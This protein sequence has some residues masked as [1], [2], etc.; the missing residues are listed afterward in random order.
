MNTLIGYA[1]ASMGFAAAIFILALAF[2]L[3][4]E[5]VK[6]SKDKDDDTN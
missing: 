6:N 5:T 3:V 1:L 4:F 2:A